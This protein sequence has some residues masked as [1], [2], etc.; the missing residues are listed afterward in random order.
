MRMALPILVALLVVPAS[1]VAAET[2]DEARVFYE[3]AQYE[4]ALETLVTLETAE[5]AVPDRQTVRRYK[6]LCLIALDRTRDAEQT[7]EEMVRAE[8]RAVPGSDA[9]P[10]MQELTHAVRRKLAP[11]LARERYERGRSFYQHDQFADAQRELTTTLAIIDDPSLDLA[12]ELADLRML[13]E[14]FLKLTSAWANVAAREASPRAV[15]ATAVVVPP[16]QHVAPP[17]ALAQPVPPL[18]MV[19]Y[20]TGIGPR[21]GE[22]EVQVGADGRVHDARIVS[23]ISP[24]FDLLLLAAARADWRYEPARQDGVAVPWTVR[25]RVV[26]RK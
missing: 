6:A 26:I 3:S 15:T 8:P 21:N 16:A 10:R 7:V 13:A 11:V 25:V 19:A 22:I 4:R 23:S 20:R 17:K 18:D 24:A 2:L 14:G 9:P 5:I 12:G 1:S